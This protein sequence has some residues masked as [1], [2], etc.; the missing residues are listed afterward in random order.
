M[1]RSSRRLTRDRAYWTGLFGN[2]RT[3][4]QYITP[5]SD[6]AITLG[7]PKARGRRARRRRDRGAASGVEPQSRAV[8]R[9]DQR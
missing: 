2:E 4:Q 5:L 1:Q 6:G 3:W 8:T 7:A 9:L